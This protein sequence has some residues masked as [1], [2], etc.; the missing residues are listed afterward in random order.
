[1]ADQWDDDLDAALRTL[2]DDVPEMD[3]G[4]F[5]AGRARLHAA[6]DAQPVAADVA[7]PVVLALPAD[8]RRRS[9]PM[10]G[11]APWVGVA[12]TVAAVAVA[13]VVLASSDSAPGGSGVGASPP[14]SAST[15][16]T[17]LPPMPAAPLNPAGDLA[18]KVSDFGLQPGQVHYVR[19][20]SSEA[21]SEYGPGGTVLDELWI[22][23]DRNGEWLLRRTL[24]G[25]PAGPYQNGEKRAAGGRF[26]GVDNPTP[27]GYSSPAQTN[28]AALPRD[29]AALYEL[30]R[31]DTNSLAAPMELLNLLTD[32]QDRVPADLRAAV[33]RVFGY[34]PG[35]TML[36]DATTTDGRR[37]VAIRVDSDGRI[38]QELLLDPDTARFLE[39]R[40]VALVEWSSSGYHPGQTITSD[41]RSEAVVSALGERP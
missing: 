40:Q 13:A 41:Q 33:L 7:D 36:P 5:A 32:K 35:V 37:A 11:A 27:G 1:M 34:L 6:I 24:S 12:A 29:P 9:P 8:R 39:W 10:R 19:W 25:Q 17:P 23:Y 38:R 28:P 20:A 31:T 18:A 15:P 30:L 14:S 21:P 16:P 2:R 22:P 26:D 3:E 4:A